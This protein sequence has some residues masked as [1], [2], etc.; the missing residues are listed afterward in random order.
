M[1]SRGKVRYI[2]V[3]TTSVG[4]GATVVNLQPSD[5]KQW[6][7]MYAIAF[8]ADVGAVNV[9]WYCTDPAASGS[10]TYPISLAPNTM[11]PLGAIASAGAHQL[12]GPLKCTVS[13]Y[14]SFVFTASAAAKHGYIYAIV[15]EFVG[16]SDA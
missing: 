2:A 13:R 9:G 12:L 5:G 15:E 3:D 7:I 16:V 6:R 1:I 11:L 14:Y 4:A 10:L 8:H